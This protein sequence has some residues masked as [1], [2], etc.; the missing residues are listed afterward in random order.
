MMQFL[1]RNLYRLW[2]FLTARTPK[3]CCCESNVSRTVARWAGFRTRISIFF[4]RKSLRSLKFPW[5]DRVRTF[6]TKF[7]IAAEDIFVYQ[8]LSAIF[9]LSID[10]EVSYST[11]V[12][13]ITKAW[14][15]LT[16][17]WLDVFLKQL[18]EQSKNLNQ[19]D[20][21]VPQM[22]LRS[23]P[24]LY[25]VVFSRPYGFFGIA[26]LFQNLPVL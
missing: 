2:N 15:Y 21:F 26:W 25:A 8:I 23:S 3:E 19:W 13:F 24:N 14:I 4:W 5:L 7:S 9:F 6:M 17:K 20:F 10:I 18:V 1:W 16:R 12:G 11:N 22:R